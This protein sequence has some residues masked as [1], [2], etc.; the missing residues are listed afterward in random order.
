MKRFTIPLLILVFAIV[1]GGAG[2]LLGGY[3]YDNPPPP[4][5]VEQVAIGEV[6]PD[7]QRT[8]SQGHTRRLAEWRGSRV[9]VNYWAS[10][11]PPC[12]E[13][14]PMLDA[15]AQANADRGVV[16]IGI[17]EDDPQAVAQFLAD[18]PVAYPILLPD[19]ADGSSMQLG[20]SRN[21]LPYTVLIGADGRL[22][23]RRA[24]VLD[25]ALLDAWL[26]RFD[27]DD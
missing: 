19:G 8:D 11:C 3:F 15:Y 16:V 5:G 10:W 26:D 20:N 18:H 9:I 12:I 6:V 23:D 13:E 22:L 21:V 25:E 4:P 1:G 27:R 14:M 7:F 17:A 24:G 2:F